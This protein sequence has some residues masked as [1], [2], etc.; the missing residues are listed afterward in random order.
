MNAGD[1]II[2]RVGITH[3]AL[4]GTGKTAPDFRAIL[5][6]AAV[7]VVSISIA[8][9]AIVLIGQT[10][11]VARAILNTI[12]AGITVTRAAIVG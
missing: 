1:I 6:T 11:K 12:V 4:I 2:A 10:T 5:N 7:V 9:A 8:H 3:A